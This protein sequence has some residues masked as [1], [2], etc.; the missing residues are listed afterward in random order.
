MIIQ[1]I[2]NGFVAGSAYALI[3]LSFLLIYLPTRFFNFAHGAIFTWGAYFCY[4]CFIL[5]G[6]PLW[7]AI[8]VGLIMAAGLGVVVEMG[9]YRHMRQR[10]ATR[11][12][13]LL[14]SMGL[15]VVFQNL[16]SMLFGDSTKSLRT[17][18][19]T[20]GIALFDGRLTNIQLWIIAIC[21]LSFII[22]WIIL[23][24]SKFGKAFRAVSNDP[25]LAMISGIESNKIILWSFAIGS[26]LGGAA[27]ILVAL[28]TNITPTMGLNA[29]MLGV[30]AVIIGGIGSVSGIAIGAFFLA[31]TQQ[32]GGWQI[33]SQWQDCIAFI[34]LLVFLIFRPEGF[35]G[36]KLRKA[37]V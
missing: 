13:L 1:Y 32:L 15:Y 11:L 20:E 6:L 3:A 22:M 26:A 5:L 24:F 16:I 36:R 23:K 30:V 19:V 25:E 28:D 18:Q 12:V 2:L 31:M 14:A 34:I 17:G 37:E 27:G 33:S 29:L 35:L 4:S 9:I 7:G 10:N 21:F 8:L